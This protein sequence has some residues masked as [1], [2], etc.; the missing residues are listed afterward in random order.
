MDNIIPGYKGIMDLDLNLVDPN[1]NPK[2]GGSY[3]PWILE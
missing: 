1:V 3:G 2:L